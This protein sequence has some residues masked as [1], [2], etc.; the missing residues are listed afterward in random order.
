MGE[1]AQGETD[2][3]TSCGY[4]SGSG[5]VRVIFPDTWQRCFEGVRFL[6]RLGGSCRPPFGRVIGIPAASEG[7]AGRLLVAKD[8]GYLPESEYATLN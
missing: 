6:W 7:G 5:I 3:V 8:L 4:I 1:G 2:R